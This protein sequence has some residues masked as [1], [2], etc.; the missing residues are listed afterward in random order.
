MQQEGLPLVRRQFGEQGQQAVPLLLRGQLV[1]RVRP[2]PVREQVCRGGRVL[3]EVQ[4]LPPVL[5]DLVPPLLLFRREHVGREDLLGFFFEGEVRLGLLLEPLFQGFVQEADEP[6]V[7]GQV[8]RALREPLP[9]PDHDLVQQIGHRHFPAVERPF[10]L[11][12]A[13]LA[14]G[15]LPKEAELRAEQPEELRAAPGLRVPLQQGDDG[16][17]VGAPALL[18]LEDVILADLVG[19][20]LDLGGQRVRQLVQCGLRDLVVR[21]GRQRAGGQ[22]NDGPGLIPRGQVALSPAVDR[23][24][25]IPA[26][27]GVRGQEP[28]QP[29]RFLRPVLFQVRPGS[30]VQPR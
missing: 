25:Q 8:P 19:V 28:V 26:V 16:V 2:L 20:P 30:F 22:V 11:Q 9:G 12:D 14:A 18:P 13:Q 6:Q 17:E 10:Q 3:E 23:Q 29:R 5:P 15:V 7:Q 21:L 24:P 27:W 4:L 1:P